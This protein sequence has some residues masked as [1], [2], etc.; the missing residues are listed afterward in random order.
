DYIFT[1]PPFGDNKMY[2]EL[3][4]LSEAWIKVKTNNTKEAIVNKVQN[5]SEV[6]YKA[7]MLDTFKEYYRVLKPK[8][9]ITIEFN[10]SKS[11]I[12]NLIQECILKSGFIIAQVSVLDKKQGSFKQVTSANSVKSDLVIS[13][14]KPQESFISTV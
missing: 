1:D 5:K 7:L 13:A 2:S 3:N 8:R 14:F 6:E 12:W 10:N 4:F 9:W 11:S